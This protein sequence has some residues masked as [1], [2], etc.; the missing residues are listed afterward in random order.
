LPIDDVYES[1]AYLMSAYGIDKGEALRRLRLQNEA[2][3][4]RG[5]LAAA[6]PDQ[7]AG[8]WLD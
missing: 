8:M 5:T 3:T 1:V 7:F 4:L 2:D 6:A